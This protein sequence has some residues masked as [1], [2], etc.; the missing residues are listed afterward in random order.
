D[1]SFAYD[2]ER[3]AHVVELPRYRIDL[4]PVTNAQYLAFMLDGGYRSRAL[5]TDAGWLWLKETG[6][7][8][9]ARWVPGAGERWLQRCLGR[10]PPSAPTR[11]GGASSAA[12]R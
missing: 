10:R 5:W 4:A 7:W 1:R 9:P 12:I 11:A 8:H 3:P 6:V 2:N